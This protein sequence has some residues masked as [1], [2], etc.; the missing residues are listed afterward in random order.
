MWHNGKCT[1]IYGKSTSLKKTN[2]PD[3]PKLPA[4]NTFIKKKTYV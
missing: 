1:K 4:G 3:N 2:Q